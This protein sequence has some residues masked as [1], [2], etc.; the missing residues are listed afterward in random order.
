MITSLDKVDLKLISEL[1]IFYKCYYSEDNKLFNE[2]YLPWLLHKNPHGDGISVN[3]R[4]ENELVA[5]MFLVPIKLIKN[6]REKYAYYATDVLTHP[7]HRDKNLFVKLIRCSIDFLKEQNS[8]LIG[9]PNSNALPGWKRT[10]MNFQ[11]IIKSFLSKPSLCNKRKIVTDISQVSAS[12]RKDINDILS[13]SSNLIVDSN[14]DFLT[15]RYINHPVRK[16]N[17]EFIYDK[18]TLVGVI[19]S[20]KFKGIIDR[21]IHYIAASGAEG[22]VFNSKPVPRIFSFSG[23]KDDDIYKKYLYGRRIGS[24]INYFMTDYSSDSS[25]ADGRYIS[26]AACDN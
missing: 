6:G 8:C 10:K 21:V 12:D 20:V 14:M 13:C 19:V 9:H 23:I 4:I 25:C 1:K 16:Y 2:M 18:H 26:F 17:V 15:W 7:N 5:N 22:K 11:P 24:E 3:I